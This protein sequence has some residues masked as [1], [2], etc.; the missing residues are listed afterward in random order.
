VA[1]V[2]IPHGGGQIPIAAGLIPGWIRGFAIF[3]LDFHIP[4]FKL[5]GCA[6]TK[7]TLT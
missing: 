2:A 6:Y 1:W 7:M 4:R 3:F 5:V